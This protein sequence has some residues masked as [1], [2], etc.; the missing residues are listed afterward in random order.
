MSEN[1]GSSRSWPNTLNTSLQGCDSNLFSSVTNWHHL[2]KRRSMAHT[3]SKAADTS[4]I[5]NQFTDNSNT[6]SS[7]NLWIFILTH[8]SLLHSHFQIYFRGLQMANDDRIWALLTP[9]QMKH[10]LFPKWSDSQASLLRPL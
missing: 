9:N 2:L 4:P 5:L 1:S 8:L 7:G 3:I 10:S 6:Q